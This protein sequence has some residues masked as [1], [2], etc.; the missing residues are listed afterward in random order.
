MLIGLYK[1]LI[2]MKQQTCFFALS[3]FV[4]ICSNATDMPRDTLMLNEFTIFSQKYLTPELRPYDVT[5]INTLQIEQSA[6]TSLLPIISS[7]TPGVFVSERGFVG[8]GI[9]AGGAGAVNIRGVGQGNK[10]LFLIDG[11]PQWAG[12]FGH[13][14][15]DTYGVSGVAAVE[16]V[17]GPSSLLYGSNAMGGSVNIITQRAKK[18]GYYGSARAML[19]SFSTQRFDLSSHLRRGKL[20]A[21]VSAQIDHSNGNRANS[22]YWGANEFA[23][24]EYELSP[25]WV[26]GSN[27]YLTQSTADYPGTTH[28]PILSMW[29][30]IFRYTLSAYARNKYSFGEGS[31]QAYLNHGRHKID[32]GYEPNE[33]PSQELFHSTDHNA[34][35]SVTQ[36]VHPWQ[37]SDITV[38]FDWQHWGGHTWYVAKDSDVLRDGI[39]KTEHSVGVFALVQQAVH[40]ILSVNV[41]ARYQRG[42]QY[43][44]EWIPQAGFTLQP[45][46][47]SEVRFIFSKGFRAPNIREL[48]IGSAANAD[49]RSEYLYNYEVTFAKYFFDKQLQVEFTLYYIDAKEMIQSQIVD[50][51]ARNMNT[52]SFVNKGFEAECRYVINQQW[53]FSANY[54]YLHTT[55]ADLLSAPKNMLRGELSYTPGNFAFTVQSN[56]VWRLNTGG[57]E[58]ENYSL[59]N[60]RL[61]YRHKIMPF[62]KLDNIT[63]KHYEIIY[64]CPMPGTTIMG[65]VQLKF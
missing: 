65:G 18:D 40:K 47:D 4:C 10:V 41:G 37:G 38:G 49:L 17:K 60:L 5:T 59:L 25:A 1:F 35:V 9:S 20:S 15:A 27:V 55:S 43:G 45:L 62:I 7:S 21:S 32:D 51:R 48:Y 58:P 6:E 2:I 54:G 23:Q 42:S 46:T 56:S 30:N 39:N 36:T 11:Q 16:V 53:A 8:Y 44:N 57:P 24:V 31:V 12:V 50:G 28:N 61:A 14:V 33:A 26:V 34:G 52:G 13:S 29:T 22:E 19:G 3:T 63:N 64:G